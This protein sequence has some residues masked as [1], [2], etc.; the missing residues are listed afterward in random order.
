MIRK[1]KQVIFLGRGGLIYDHR[2][3]EYLIDSEMSF[4]ENVD[5]IIFP[6]SIKLKEGNRAL[7]ESDIKEVLYS[8]LLYLKDEEKLKVLV[9]N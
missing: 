4:T 8:L 2:N 5:I 9:H 3:I 1:K 7:S 6:D